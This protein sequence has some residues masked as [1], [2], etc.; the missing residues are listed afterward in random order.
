M[1]S[2]A[3]LASHPIHPMLVALPIG[4]WIGSFVFDIL[5]RI[6]GDNLLAAAGFYA[7]LA[8]CMGAA[9]AAVPGAIDLF[10]TVP[11]RSS[12][13]QRGYIH[14]GLNVL[15]LALFISVCWRRGG[16]WFPSDRGSLWLSFFGLCTIAVSGWLGGTLAYRNQIGVD[17]RY[18]NA[19]KFKSR[20]IDEFS[21]P[22]CHQ[23]ELSDGELMLVRVGSERIAVGRTAQG[24]V[25]F[26]DHC[27]H[28]G[29][30]LCD[31]AL[32]GSTVQC[33]WHGSQFDCRTGRVIAG[34]AEQP[35]PIYGV[36]IRNGEVYLVHP[37]VED[38][39]KVA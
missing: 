3:N 10:F 34:P 36:E 28:K 32:I 30:P 24:I 38:L 33:P 15:A 23:S 20:S 7:A 9:L 25:A 16:P 12:A 18:A 31:G 14:G 22:A 8:G 6:I 5:G 19:T 1:R 17:R 29:G 4:L 21:K 39:R 13:R 26:S 27:T 35:I 11:P 37:T 2:T